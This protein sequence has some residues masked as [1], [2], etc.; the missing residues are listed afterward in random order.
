MLSIEFQLCLF[1]A[2]CFGFLISKTEMAKVFPDDGKSKELLSVKPSNT[3][4]HVGIAI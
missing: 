3:A 4:W 1:V 2:L